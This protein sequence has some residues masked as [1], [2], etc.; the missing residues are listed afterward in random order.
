MTASE[1]GDAAFGFIRRTFDTY[2]KNCTANHEDAVVLPSQI[3]CTHPP[4]TKFFDKATSVRCMWLEST[5]I[6]CTF[7]VT[8][9]AAL[10]ALHVLVMCSWS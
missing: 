9:G 5:S 4:G 3:E 2:V 6:S 8:R 7:V 1:T 10:R